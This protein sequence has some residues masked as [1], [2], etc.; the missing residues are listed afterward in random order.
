M[1]TEPIDGNLR[2]QWMKEEYPQCRVVHY[3]KIVPQ[4]PK[5][6]PQFWDIWT[7][8][9]KDAHP[10]KIDIVFSSEEY[11]EPLAKCVGAVH[12]CV[13][14]NR[15]TVP[16]S[17]TKIR[18]N[19]LKYWEYIPL[20][21]RPY[22]AKKVLIVGPESTGKSTLTTKLA[23]HFGGV[24]IQE[25]AREWITEHDNTFEYKDLDLFAKKQH[26]W[27]QNGTKIGKPFVFIDTDSI[28]TKIFSE[29]YYDSVSE[30]V[31]NHTTLETYDCI[32]LTDISVSWENDGQRDLGHRREEVFQRFVKELTNRKLDFH[33]VSDTGEKR[34]Q[35]AI[36][37]VEEILQIEKKE[38]EV[39]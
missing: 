30:T 37:I 11:G 14:L 16:I 29:I 12:H 9:V 22:F 3:D 36:R 35:N 10:E 31:H 19:P 32:L 6:H 23:K 18:N 1:P 4:E 39:Q 24:D 25:Y 7:K 5:E 28:V 27:I 17:A 20:R 21:V 33:I 2:Y 34:L 38:E 8:I 26:E 15:K 13:D